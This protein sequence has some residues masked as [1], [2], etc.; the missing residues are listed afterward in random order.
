MGGEEVEVV[1][2]GNILKYFVV[3][4]ENWDGVFR[5]RF[6]DLRRGFI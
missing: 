4:M 5:G 6:G 1:S 3:N 2:I